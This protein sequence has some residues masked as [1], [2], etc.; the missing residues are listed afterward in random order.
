MPADRS[1]GKN[2]GR[3]PRLSVD[4]IIA[5][6][7][8]ILRAEGAEKLSMRR[9]A[10]ELDS[11]PMALYYHVR[12][13]DELL[14]LVIES[15]AR[16]LPRPH[17]PEDPKERLLAAALT[18]YELLSERLWIVEV[19]TSDG[20]AAPSAMWM[21]EAMLQASVDYGHTPDHSV[22]VY[23]TIW[24][25]IV[26]NLMLRLNRERRRAHTD[27]PVHCDRIIADLPPDTHPRL[28]AASPRWAELT[29]RDTHRE[30]LAAIVD[31]LLPDR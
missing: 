21:V 30:A 9:L 17:F 22:Y 10:A 1:R 24:N 12:D 6:A 27:S 20:L 26:G 14:L 25:Y 11:T 5:A 29:S 8:R 4:A 18:L 13:K 19:L 16:R 3:P 2:V 7:D 28:A 31:A 15:H 23:R